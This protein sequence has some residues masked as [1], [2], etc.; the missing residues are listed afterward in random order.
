M[1]YFPTKE[2]LKDGVGYPPATRDLIKLYNQ[3]KTMGGN[4]Y[5]FGPVHDVPLLWVGK[6]ING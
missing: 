6:E 1:R 5:L 2:E 4:V 3:L